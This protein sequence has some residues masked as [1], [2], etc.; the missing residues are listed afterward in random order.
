MGSSDSGVYGWYPIA[1]ELKPAKKQEAQAKKTVYVTGEG[2]K[3]DD[4]SLPRI[5]TGGIVPFVLGRDIVRNP[6][7]IW[8]G[9]LKPVSESEVSQEV[10]TDA[11]TGIETIVTTIKTT[12]VR[13]TV[14]IQFCLG[15]GP[16]MRLRSIYV[17]NVPAWTGTQGPARSTFA[18]VGNPVLSDI[19][20]AGGNFDQGID[21][22]IQSLVPQSLPAYRGLAYV[23][24][25]GLDTSKLGNLSFE[26]DRYPD[27]L[28]LGAHN[29][30]GDD[31]NPAS[32]IAEII[33]SK[34]GGA[35]QDV[36]TLGSS[37]TTLAETFFTEGNG[38]SIVNRNEVSANDL[39]AILLSQV[40]GT[41]Y[42]NHETGKLELSIFR[43]DFD[44]TNLIRVFDR[45]IIAINDMNK[46]SWQSIPTSIK[47][48]YFDRTLNY[49]EIPLVAR[50]LATSDK[51]SKSTSTKSF[52]AVR[53]GV[54]A[55]KLLSR[56]GA[57]SGSPT[58]QI[59][60]TTN[61]KTA[62]CNP[63]D[64]ILITCAKYR[65]YSMP[66]IVIKR[67]AQPPETNSVTLVCN[68]ILYPNNTVLFAAP[69]TGFFE[70]LDPNPHAPISV[71][72]IS[73]PWSLRGSPPPTQPP[74]STSVDYYYV[75][76]VTNDTLLVF[77]DAFNSI[78]Q[79]MKGHYRYNPLDQFIDLWAVGGQITSNVTPTAGLPSAYF[80]FPGVGKLTTAI[81]KFDNW[82]GS[83]ATETIVIKNLGLKT[84][85]ID[86]IMNGFNRDIHFNVYIFIGD[87]IFRWN[88]QIDPVNTTVVY[89][90][91]L[92][93]MTFT[94]VYRGIFDTV[95]QSHAV[96]DAVYIMPAN[97]G[98][99]SGIGI[100]YG[101]TAEMVFTGMASPK[102]VLT[103]SNIAT[104][105]TVSHLGTDRA[106]RP[107][108][109]HNTKVN[110]A[111]GTSSPTALVRNTTATISW[112]VRGRNRLNAGLYPIQT[113]A[114]QAA[115]INGSNKHVVYRVKLTD[116]A[117]VV[118]D[119]G[120]TADTADH[121]N[122]VVTIPLTAAAGVGVLWVQA[123]Y[124]PGSG[125]KVSLYNDMMPVNLT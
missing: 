67:R 4:V 85:A 107:L 106:N 83:S 100:F 33:T 123:E 103:E 28:A 75:G 46:N 31:I 112:F 60:L 21:S 120:A 36:A 43:K 69:E 61:R 81:D 74:L 124:N 109:A 30:I 99:Q 5:A 108:R 70:S 97:P 13:Y 64:I 8:Y 93:T 111:R 53:D 92:R 89:N 105:Y 41:L 78:Q 113:E 87:E 45:D 88:P 68:V 65:Y 125:V 19:I 121:S 55:N 94:G 48:S 114:S 22:Y 117:A 102:S 96:N 12:I 57:N 7:I 6:D 39:N 2:K 40:T 119:L 16:G 110:G 84:L 71:A 32:A 18:V 122:L 82:D 35:G 27:P 15:L 54:L 66:A 1:G 47:V 10:V 90:A 80:S 77:G 62:N 9:N 26:V 116:S 23:V 115:E 72:A 58:Q 52:P 50:N 14:D 49:K 37:F 11:T 42:E 101:Q 24:L 79:G 56:E 51:V 34:W 63:G 118:W 73:A 98:Y 25:R 17:D 76:E 91:A 29:K 59:S 3:A 20:F 86:T 95:A 44:R 104:G 38:C